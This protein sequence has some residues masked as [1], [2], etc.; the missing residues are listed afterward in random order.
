[1]LFQADA[2]CD[3]IKEGSRPPYGFSFVSQCL[4]AISVIVPAKFPNAVRSASQRCPQLRAVF[5]DVRCQQG[6]KSHATAS[7]FPVGNSHARYLCFN[8]S[9]DKCGV[10]LRV[11]KGFFE[12]VVKLRCL[13]VITN[14]CQIC[15][16]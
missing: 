7:E 9:I 3:C 2:C 10:K 15:N 8:A 16:R 14:M 5:S 4:F 6:A 11:A 12:C 1:M 13:V